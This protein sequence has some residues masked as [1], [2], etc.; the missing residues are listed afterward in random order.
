MHTTDTGSAASNGNSEFTR[1]CPSRDCRDAR[2]APLKD[3]DIEVLACIAARLAGRDP[4][5]HTTIEIGG[6]VA[7]DDVAWRYPDF[8]ARAEAAYS[9]L[10]AKGLSE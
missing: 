6:V 1:A 3:A 5:G 9:V 7:F 8:I 4:D 2:C 10:G